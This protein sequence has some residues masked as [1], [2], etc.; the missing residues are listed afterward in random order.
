TPV[1]LRKEIPGFLVNRIFRAL[2]REAIS[3][4]EQGYASAEDIDLAVTKGLGHPMGPL[5]LIDTTGVDVSY[6][7]RMDEY[8]ETGV[9]SAKP[10]D[11]L[12]VMYEKGEWG[13]KSGKGFY[14][15]KSED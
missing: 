1:V 3:L 9:E 8:N 7:A 6:L 5:R 12:K 13:K 15:Y 14:D 2:T 10:N 11:I 4:Y